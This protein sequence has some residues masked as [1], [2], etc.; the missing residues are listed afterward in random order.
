MNIGFSVRLPV[1][2]SSV[3]FARAMCR[4][5]LEHLGIAADVT[6]DITLALTE[7]CANVVRHSGGPEHYEVQVDIG[8][9][10]CRIIVLDSGGGFQ[11]PEPDAGEGAVPESGRGVY[12]MQTL[13]DELHFRRDPQLGHRVV[14]EK[15]LTGKTL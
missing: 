14:L 9:D 6:S 13:M 3:P 10:L 12:L 8:P 7:A 15:R 5:A 4:N 1:D 11:M 2:S